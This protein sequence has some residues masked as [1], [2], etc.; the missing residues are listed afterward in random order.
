VVAGQSVLVIGASGGVGTYAVQIAK[1]LGA[2]VTGVCSPAKLE[3]VRSIGADDVLDYT[4]MD[5]GESGARYDVILDIAGNRS[6]S[7]LRRALSARGTLV[8]A[9]GEDGGRWI[10]GTDRQLRALALSAFV[11]HR[12]RAFVSKTQTAGLRQ[13]TKLIESGQ[14]AP[15]LDR[16]YPLVDAPRALSDLVAGRIRGKAAVVI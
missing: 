4:K 12:L 13:V 9:G 5:I 2:V 11:R 1:S 16:T 7:Q 15:V 6:I 14:V 8:I 3:L 10:G